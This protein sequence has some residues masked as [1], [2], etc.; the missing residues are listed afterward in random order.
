M[1][2]EIKF[3]AWDNLEQK[4]RPPFSLFSIPEWTDRM[5]YNEDCIAMQYTG[6]RD[7]NGVEIYEGDIVA[8]LRSRRWPL[9]LIHHRVVKWHEG[10]NFCGWNIAVNTTWEVVGNVYENPELLANTKEI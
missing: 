4:M 8:R 2:R 9:K 5:L 10:R 6:L 3:R 7:K 1:T